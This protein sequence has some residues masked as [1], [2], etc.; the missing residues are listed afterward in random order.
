M[1]TTM[2]K[3][4]AMMAACFCLSF[5]TLPGAEQPKDGEKKGPNVSTDKTGKESPPSPAAAA[6]NRVAMARSLIKYGRESKS[7][8]S[9]IAAA[10]IL[11]RTAPRAIAK[12][13][14][15][16]EEAKPANPPQG[17]SDTDPPSDEPAALL[18]EARKMAPEDAGVAALASRVASLLEERPRGRE[19]GP[20]VGIYRLPAYSS[21]TF[22]WTFAGG[23]DAAVA[24]SGDGD[25]DLDLYV[26]DENDHLIASDTDGSDDCLAA[27]RPRWTGPFVVKIVN[28]GPVSNTYKIATN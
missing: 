2:I 7:P 19:P 13:P 23:E 10:E 1:E 6:A 22:V 4:C 15:T 9:L 27:W 16:K 26:Y 20:M 17:R 8:V 12:E 28:R 5:G 11:A 3:S 18:A 14:T 24:L 25:T 21:H